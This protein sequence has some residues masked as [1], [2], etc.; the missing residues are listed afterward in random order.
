MSMEYTRI[1]VLLYA[2]KYAIFSERGK[3]F[4]EREDLIN[5]GDNA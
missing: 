5:R 2:I 1:N 4:G 3:L